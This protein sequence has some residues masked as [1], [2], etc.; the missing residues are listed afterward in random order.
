MVYWLTLSGFHFKQPNG[1][2]QRAVEAPQSFAFLS[3]SEDEEILVWDGMLL[4]AF[5]TQKVRLLEQGL[6]SALNIRPYFSYFL[7]SFKGASFCA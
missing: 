2:S 6:G 4:S 3:E 7:S 1:A 5:V